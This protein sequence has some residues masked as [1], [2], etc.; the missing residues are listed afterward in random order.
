M[1][2][3]FL[4]IVFIVVFSYWVVSIIELIATHSFNRLAFNI[5]IPIAK[6]TIEMPTGD[7]TPKINAT[8]KGSE[9]KFCFTDDGKVLFLS[10][11][12]WFK[13]F[14]FN[15][16]FPIKVVGTINK[17]NTIDLIVRLPVGPSLI[18]GVFF[19][20]SILSFFEVGMFLT[21][22]GF[23]MQH[24]I[25]FAIIIGISYPIE[26]KRLGLMI[27]DLKKIISGV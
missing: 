24:L 15:S 2:E 5:G 12:F 23:R 17:N 14:R 9:G 6:R 11:H 8:I 18:F 21:E 26:K 22:I 25:F 20:C 4:T 7:F 27:E 19:I 1:D 3:S 13:F 16:V 10:Q